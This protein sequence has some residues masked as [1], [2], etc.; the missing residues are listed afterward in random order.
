[1]MKIR[2]MKPALTIVSLAA[3]QG[4]VGVMLPFPG[5]ITTQV[6]N[7]NVTYVPRETGLDRWI[8]AQPVDLSAHK[9]QTEKAMALF[10]YPTLGWYP[11]GR[12]TYNN[13]VRVAI[14]ETPLYM[15]PSYAGPSDLRPLSASS[16]TDTLITAG[17]ST[18]NGALAAAG[19]V[20]SLGPSGN[21]D[22][23]T[24]QS[25]FLCYKAQDKYDANSAL[26]SCWKDWLGQMRSIPLQQDELHS[27]DIV[28]FGLTVPTV[29]GR[30]GHARMALNRSRTG[31]FVGMAPVQMG[32]Y[33]AH[34]FHFNPIVRA[35]P[36]DPYTVEDLIAL[37]EKNKP[38]DIV[39]LI[40]GAADTRK[41][42]GVDPV[43]IVD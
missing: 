18:G 27:M 15:R 9:T 28:Q 35:L 43:G 30:E 31:Y 5:E 29:E 14:I 34:I 42:F 16:A 33:K 3:L 25:H 26:Q 32:G 4:C 19:A 10:G 13:T 1:M 6:E 21:A 24:R 7:M 39:Y 23:R 38:S 22:P 40:A 8:N 37:L 11:E 17:L 12:L 2:T 36:G 41:R 20:A